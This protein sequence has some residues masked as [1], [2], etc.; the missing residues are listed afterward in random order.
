VIYTMLVLYIYISWYIPC[1]RSWQIQ[2]HGTGHDVYHD[3]YVYIYHDVYSAIYHG[4]LANQIDSNV[5]LAHPF[6]FYIPMWELSMPSDG[7]IGINLFDLHHLKLFLKNL[8][9][10][11]T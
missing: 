2:W 1:Y 5:P 10:D 9:S 7:I 8:C 3:T 6:N 4:I 11:D